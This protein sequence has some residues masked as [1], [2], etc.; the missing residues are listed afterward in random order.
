MNRR[1]FLRGLVASAVALTLARHLPGI[2]AE[3]VGLPAPAPIED[4]DTGI[5]IRFIKQFDIEGP[6]AR[7][8]VL[9]GFSAN[10][11]W[12]CKVTA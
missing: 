11:E 7:F 10:P 3:P 9:Y 12:A 5:S 6:V 4:H 2:A 8:D 1:R